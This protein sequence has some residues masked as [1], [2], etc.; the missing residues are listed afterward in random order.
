MW[1]AARQSAKTCPKDRSPSARESN[2][3]SRVGSIRRKR[4][5]RSQKFE[6]RSQNLRTFY[7]R[8][9]RIHRTEGRRARPHR[10]AA[11]ARVPRLRLSGRGGRARRLRGPSTERGQALEP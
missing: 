6:V 8:D 3:T 4:K 2:V 10:R 11:A 9:Y 5:V 7:V 1:A